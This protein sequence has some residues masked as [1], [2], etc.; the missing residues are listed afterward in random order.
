MIS[1]IVIVIFTEKLLNFTS[2]LNFKIFMCLTF[3]SPLPSKQQYICSISSSYKC[4]LYVRQTTNNFNILYVET[5]V[6]FKSIQQYLP[7]LNNCFFHFK[8]PIYH[9]GQPICC[10]FVLR[11]LQITLSSQGSNTIDNSF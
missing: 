11:H 9:V 1:S 8:T 10:G 3:K 5:S 6:F 2:P 7:R 4:T